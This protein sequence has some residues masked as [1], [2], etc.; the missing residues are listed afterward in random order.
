MRNQLREG[1]SGPLRVPN[2]PSRSCRQFFSFD[3]QTRANSRMTGRRRCVNR[4]AR[5]R[6]APGALPLPREPSYCGPNMEVTWSLVR[7]A[8][9]AVLAVSYFL[10]LAQCPSVP[11]T[12]DINQSPDPFDIFAFSAFTWPSFGSIVA[13]ALFFW[14]VV[15]ELIRTFRPRKR[16]R[17]GLGLLLILCVLSLA[18]VSWLVVWG[19]T[20]RYGAFAAYGAIVGYTM[21]L[22][23]SNRAEKNSENV[24]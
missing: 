19:R 8:A 12:G 10:P 16:V 6:R 13:L 4:E 11:R 14:P 3:E 22:V 17:F 5:A 1:R 9:A 21:A 18:A 2:L 24:R 15:T 20:I 7:R 23:A